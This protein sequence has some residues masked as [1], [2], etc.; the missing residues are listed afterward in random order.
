MEPGGGDDEY[1]AP[2]QVTVYEAE[3]P[4]VQM[5]LAVPVE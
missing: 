2:L 3:L 1:T 4:G 5:K